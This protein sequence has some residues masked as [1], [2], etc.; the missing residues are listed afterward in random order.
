MN[1]NEFIAEFTEFA[2]LEENY[3]GNENLNDFD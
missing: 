2:E 1:L 3:P